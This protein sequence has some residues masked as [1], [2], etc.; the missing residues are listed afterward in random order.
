MLLYAAHLNKGNNNTRHSLK[1]YDPQWKQNLKRPI[2]IG[3][4]IFIEEILLWLY[5]CSIWSE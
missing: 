3:D 5:I 1:D 2:L 4:G